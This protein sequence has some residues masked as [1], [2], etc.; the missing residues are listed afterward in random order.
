MSVVIPKVYMYVLRGTTES[1]YSHSM[2][3]IDLNIATSTQN[4]TA[5]ERAR[6][7]IVC[8]SNST[9]LFNLGDYDQ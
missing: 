2:A 7:I 3:I 6:G 5:Q 1:Y 4:L 8:R 9:G